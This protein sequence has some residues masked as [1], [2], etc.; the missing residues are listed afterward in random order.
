MFSSVIIWGHPLHSHTHSYIHNAFFRAFEA[1]G[2]PVQWTTTPEVAQ[3]DALFITEGQVD[4]DIPLRNDCYYLV[5]NCSDK[6]D[7]LPRHRVLRL[8][9]FT[10]KCLDAD[11]FEGKFI[12]MKDGCL[13]MPWATDLLPSEI[14][15]NLANLEAIVAQQENRK[16]TF[17]GYWIGGPWDELREYCR[18][19][20][21]QLEHCGG[22]GNSNVTIEENQRRVQNAAYAPAFQSDWQ[23]ENGYIPCRFFKNISYGGV[24]IT[25]NRAVRELFDPVAECITYRDTPSLAMDAIRNALPT[26]EQRKQAME[27]VRDHHTYLNRIQTIERAFQTL[28]DTNAPLN[29]RRDLDA[30]Q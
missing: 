7:K 5:H 18:T 27:F 1:L 26:L 20:N 25:T 24:G 30:E 12:R 10:W 15:A 11:E 29:T 6:Y 4:S 17:V 13:Y 9:V 16:V 22:F 3:K 28:S 23:L 21:L 14:D 2:I 19:N 8:Q